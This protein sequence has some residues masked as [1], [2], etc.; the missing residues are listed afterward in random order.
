VIIILDFLFFYSNSVTAAGRQKTGPIFIQ[1]GNKL[2]KFKRKCLGTTEYR[3]TI[4]KII[5][6]QII[7][8]IEYVLKGRADINIVI[9]EQLSGNHRWYST[10]PNFTWIITHWV[11][12]DRRTKRV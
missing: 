10:H 4:S 12:R 11:N 1:G 5:F 9:K 7:K 8:T 3:P 6:S 2:L